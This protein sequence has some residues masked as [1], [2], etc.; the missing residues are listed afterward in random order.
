MSTLDEQQLPSLSPGPNSS[1]DSGS[2]TQTSPTSNGSPTRTSPT[3]NLRLP[4][5]TAAPS[6]QSPLASPFAQTPNLSTWLDKKK[7]RNFEDPNAPFSPTH[8]ALPIEM[9]AEKKEVL[10]AFMVLEGQEVCRVSDFAGQFT[11]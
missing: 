1:A 6:S 4:P 9:T 5:A 8:L 10:P 7:D 2:P 3:S 11:R